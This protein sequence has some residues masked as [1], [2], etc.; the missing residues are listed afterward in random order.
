[1]TVTNNKIKQLQQYTVIQVIIDYCCQS[2]MCLIYTFYHIYD[3]GE[4]IVYI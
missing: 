4:N 1:M 3:T 2:L